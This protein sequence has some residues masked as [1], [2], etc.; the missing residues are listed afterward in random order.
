M[1]T[2][3]SRTRSD[4]LQRDTAVLKNEN[5]EAQPVWLASQVP[6]EV[7]DRILAFLDAHH[8]RYRPLLGKVASRV[9]GV[10][11]ACY[12]RKGEYPNGDGMQHVPAR[13][14]SD[15]QKTAEILSKLWS[16]APEDMAP[17]PDWPLAWAYLEMRDEVE[18]RASDADL[19]E[20]DLKI[21]LDELWQRVAQDTAARLE[22]IGMMPVEKEVVET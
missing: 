1:L 7:V 16:L 15:A 17:L 13:G 19:F 18:Y 2:L 8:W 11:N 21:D 6:G 5:N 12:G 3:E 22:A 14:A 20:G 9:E 10:L 4:G